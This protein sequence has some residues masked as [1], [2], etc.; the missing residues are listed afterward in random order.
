[1]V[2]SL[3]YKSE[4]SIMW[5]WGEGVIQ[6]QDRKQREYRLIE[7]ATKVFPFPTGRRGKAFC[8][9]AQDSLLFQQSRI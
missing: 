8:G 7:N 3:Q 4:T 9:A 5:G 6:G 1:M 2:G